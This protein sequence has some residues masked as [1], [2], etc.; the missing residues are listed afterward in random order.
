MEVTMSETLFLDGVPREIASV[1]I[2]DGHLAVFEFDLG[3]VYRAC[4][5]SAVDAAKLLIALGP[6]RRAVGIY[7]HTDGNTFGAYVKDWGGKWTD[8]WGFLDTLAES[9]EPI[10]IFHAWVDVDRNG[11]WFAALVVNKRIFFSRHPRVITKVMDGLYDENNECF[12][13][14]ERTGD[15]VLSSADV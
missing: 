4:T 5:P 6:V 10:Q 3:G 13:I 11:N 1:E 7:Q 14:V 12:C 8:N 15:V 9:S 2:V